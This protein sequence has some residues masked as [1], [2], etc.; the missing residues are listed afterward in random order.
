MLPRA[1]SFLNRIKLIRTAGAFATQYW[2]YEQIAALGR[3]GSTQVEIGVIA[4]TQAQT[5]AANA[6]LAERKA[7]LT[8]TDETFV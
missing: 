5:K 1:C 7:A 2:F 8:K 6:W 4:A 3:T